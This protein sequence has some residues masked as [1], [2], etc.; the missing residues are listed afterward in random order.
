MEF[1]SAIVKIH[2]KMPPTAKATGKAQLPLTKKQVGQ[3]GILARMMGVWVLNP[4]AYVVQVK[5]RK[6]LQKQIT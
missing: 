4:Y 2:V 3:S 6:K 5:D 1:S